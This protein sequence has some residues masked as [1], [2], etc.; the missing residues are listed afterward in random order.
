MKGTD[1]TGGGRYPIRNNIIPA[2]LT[3]LSLS[4]L[5]YILHLVSFELR[6]GNG[7]AAIVFASFSASAF[8][9]FMTPR[10]KAAKT[11]KFVKSYF[12]GAILGFLGFLL[13]PVI[14]TYVTFFAIILVLSLL[15]IALRAE[16]PPG[17][18][19]AFA[20]LLY[21]IDY[22]GVIVVVIG[23]IIMLFIRLFLEK[24]VYVIEGDVEMLKRRERERPGRGRRPRRAKRSG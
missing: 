18:A 23:V 6:Y 13:T 15:L 17:V 8:I 9:L 10:S 5:V 12:L 11:S 7:S 14:G 24:A 16:H 22:I 20:F 2:V 21:H 19:I 4:V 3:A 1:V